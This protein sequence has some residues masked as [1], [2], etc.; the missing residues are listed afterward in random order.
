MREDWLEFRLF[1]AFNFLRGT[2]H[3]LLHPPVEELYRAKMCSLAEQAKALASVEW[4]Q[5]SGNWDVDC[6]RGRIRF[7]LELDG[8]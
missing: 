8:I 6:T 3:W 5:P 7:P 1:V 2:F 4:Y